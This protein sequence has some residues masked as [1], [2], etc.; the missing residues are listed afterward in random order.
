MPD[1]RRNRPRPTRNRHGAEGALGKRLSNHV[2]GRD[3]GVCW[4]CGHLGA[5][6]ADHL[7]PVTERPD[8]AL[9]TANMKAAHGWPHPCETCSAAAVA[10]G[11]KPVFCNEVRGA[12]SVER[13][14]RVIE[15]RTGL[16]LGPKTGGEPRG[17][18]EW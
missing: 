13:A 15:M 10:R 5:T 8:L 11:G 3:M 4:I 9:A 6:S 16:V 2:T 7:I 18:R 12:M 14:R 1:N 17:E